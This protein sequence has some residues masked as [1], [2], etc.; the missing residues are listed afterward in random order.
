MR[1]VNLLNDIARAEDL[2]TIWNHAVRGFT[3]LGF[4]RISFGIS[5]PLGHTPDNPKQ[6]DAIALSTLPPHVKQGYFENGLFSRSALFRWGGENLG[7][8]TWSWLDRNPLSEDEIAVREQM[9][10]MGM[11][12][13]V[14]LSLPPAQTRMRAM[15]CL[16]AD[17]GISQAEVDQL[18][19]REAPQIEALGHMLYLRTC[20]LPAPITH[21]DLTPRQCEAL[22]CVASGSTMQDT[23]DRM[24]IS[25]PTV[26]KHLRLAR[27]V[28]LVEST[29]QAVAKAIALNLI[30]QRDRISL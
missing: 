26:E 9:R 18:V 10:R 25:L 12:A 14:T 24:G 15:L 3:D 23:A 11:V 4:S 5:G 13:G 20:T 27:E 28:L 19:E 2:L 6:R 22:E 7:Y 21:R 30:F 16:V 29:T 8:I 1:F 17:E